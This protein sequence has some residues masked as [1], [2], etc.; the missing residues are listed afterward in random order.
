MHTQT[1]LLLLLL[2]VL[3]LHFSL[4]S[5]WNMD[6]FYYCDFAFLTLF[7]LTDL[8]TASFSCYYYI[9]ALWV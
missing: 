4:P 9:L 7:Q 5:W 3:L 2:L 1:L 8:H 6:E